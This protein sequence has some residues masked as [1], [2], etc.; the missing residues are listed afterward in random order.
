M[1]IFILNYASRFNKNEAIINYDE[2]N[3]EI[4][5]I[6]IKNLKKEIIK[7]DIIQKQKMIEDLRNAL[8]LTENNKYLM[9]YFLD[10][11]NKYDKKEDSINNTLENLVIRE[12]KLNKE[13][14]LTLN[15]CNG[16]N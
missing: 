16:D 6:F 10:L 14:Y 11:F 3:K 12:I 5:Y 8:T 7:L 2:L 1:N 4:K 13:I 15:I 9:N